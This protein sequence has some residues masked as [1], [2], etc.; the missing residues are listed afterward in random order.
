MLESMAILWVMWKKR[1][2]PVT[3]LELGAD[4]WVFVEQVEDGKLDFVGII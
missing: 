2:E 3:I 4:F 1:L